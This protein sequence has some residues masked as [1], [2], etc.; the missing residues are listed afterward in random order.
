MLKIK[1]KDLLVKFLASKGF[2]VKEH[3]LHQF[4]KILH[5]VYP[6]ERVLRNFTRILENDY[7]IPIY[8]EQQSYLLK[9]LEV[10]LKIS[11]FSNYLT[12]VV[13]RNPEFL[14][15][16]LS[17]GELHKNFLFED[18]S[19]EL[20]QQISIYKSYD[21][22]LSAIRR[23][24]RLH[25]LRIGLRDILNICELK[26]TMLEYSYLTQTIL[27]KIYSIA[28]EI[29]KAQTTLRKIPDY[30]LISL[31][32]LGGLELNFSSDV[33]LICIYDNID[34]KYS[35]NILEFYDKVVKN[36]IQICA[37]T[38][39]GSPLYRID[40]RLRPDGKFSPLARSIS[41]Y[42]IYYESY[43]RDWERQMLLRMNYVSGNRDLFNRFYKSVENFVFPRSL[44]ISPQ[45]LIHR[46]RKIY[47]ENLENDFETKDLNLKHFL[48]GIRDVEF[49]VQALQL[50]NGGK[51]RKLRTPNTIN[52]IEK[53]VELKLIDA[54]SGENLINSYKF[55][56]KIE[57]F[58]QLMDDRQLH[59]IPQDDDKFLNLV[60]YLGL[61]NSI[62]F[63]NKL[64][65]VRE[66][67][68]NFSKKF[69]RLKTQLR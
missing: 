60:K 69:L 40:F 24:K 3:F 12:D 54:T 63:N 45:V 29:N 66:F 31:G 32:K 51:F 34:D 48:G 18:F 11:A 6:T 1:L 23:F 58:I 21:K 37:D 62:Q 65:S 49:S 50:L 68:Q 27:D 26:Q 10:I 42:Q 15:R 43:G 17:S 55:L 38:Q 8:L 52:A 19:Q 35:S 9:Y 39:D 4:E 57:N 47:L 46:F 61:K 28:F 16:F 5:E 25:L 53:L 56:R 67:V 14:T 33:D 64:K 59:T 44:L 22:K 13:V 2:I 20:D 30:V 7:Y 41:Y 36:F